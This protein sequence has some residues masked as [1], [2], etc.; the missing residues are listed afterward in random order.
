MKA[1]WI[2]SGAVML[3]AGLAASASAQSYGSG[4]SYGFPGYGYGAGYGVYHHASTYEEGVLRGLADLQRSGGEANYWHSLAAN[5]WQEAYAKYLQNREAK[6]E[7]YFRMQAINRAAREATRPQRFT[8]EQ[9]AVLAA[10]QAPDRL[11][12]AQY[13][14]TLGRLNWPAALQ[15]DQFAEERAVLDSAFAARTPSDGG[16]GSAF[17]SGVR[18]LTDS[19]QARLQSQ[20]RFMHQMDYLAA[21]KFLS[22]LAIEAQQPLV[23]EALAAAE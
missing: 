8:T 1:T 7:T 22:G 20:I 23:V 4:S 11:N 3:V 2:L 16:V 6:T 9:L 19:M 17:G 12:P 14:R 15:S 5:N 10:K 13:D 18:Q 21:K